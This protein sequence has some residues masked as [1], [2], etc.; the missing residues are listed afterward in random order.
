MSAVEHATKAHLVI[1]ALQPLH[2]ERS[3]AA[4][5]ESRP[6]QFEGVIDTNVLAPQWQQLLG[7]LLGLLSIR[8]CYALQELGQGSW[9][10]EEGEPELPQQIL[11]VCRQ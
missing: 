5:G 10:A 6:E 4:V 1:G 9:G 2:G 3:Y 8:P 11:I 7:C